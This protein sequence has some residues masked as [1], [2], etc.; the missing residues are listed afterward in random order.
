MRKDHREGAPVATHHEPIPSGDSSSDA[1]VSGAPAQPT[2]GSAPRRPLPA[3]VTAPVADQRGP[4]SGLEAHPTPAGPLD[5][6]TV[7]PDYPPLADTLPPAPSSPTMQTQPVQT[8]GIPVAPVASAPV[9]PVTSAPVPP[10]AGQVPPVAPA[11]A[12]SVPVPPVASGPV[13]PPIASAPVPPVASAP[14]PPVASAPV[15]SSPVASGPVGSAPV[16]SAGRPFSGSSPRSFP[17]SAP[18]AP[19]AQAGQP[20]FSVPGLEHVIVPGAAQPVQPAEP[21]QQQIWQRWEEAPAPA[22]PTPAAFTPPAAGV[23][24]PAGV[25][26]PVAVPTPVGAPVPTA[27]PFTDVIAPQV[28]ESPAPTKAEQRAAAKQAKADAAAAAKQAKTD[29]ATAAKQ[30]KADKAT[31]AKRSKA[32]AA[33]TAKQTKAAEADAAKQAKADAAA[34]AAQTK[35]D[36]A[37][38]AAQAE[39]DAAAAAAA[40]AAAEQARALPVPEPVL[41]VAY[42]TADPLAAEI[43]TP[44]P[45]PAPADAPEHVATPTPAPAA[46]PTGTASDAPF[47]TR[48]SQRLLEEQAGRRRPRSGPAPSSP[49]VASAPRP[50]SPF[51][52]GRRQ[53]PVAAP[54]PRRTGNTAPT[55]IV[56]TL[57]APAPAAA[58]VA[59]AENPVTTSTPAVR[60]AIGAAPGAVI[61]ALFG[62]GTLGVALWWFLNPGTVHIVAVVLGVLAVA[63]TLSTLRNPAALSWHRAMSLLGFVFGLIG[64]VVLLYAIASA[65]ASVAGITLPDVTG[66][67][68]APSLNW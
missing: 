63:L 55:P 19:E 28:A 68:I 8:G 43:I 39:A 48:R 9:P 7:I 11:A 50:T 52:I 42:A 25:P 27:V 38:A 30:A 37:A 22:L 35:A 47:P 2:P 65:F 54:G 18:L 51:R 31:A 10:V 4:V 56:A 1:Q 61:G 16:T 29:K 36:A 45:A 23:P 15:A 41:P 12:A 21:A 59:V 14:V 49:A 60:T 26:T 44:T 67:G 58:A 13:V 6:N 5:P 3:W 66:T 20:R 64:T 57:P 17:G 33:A 46:A 32:D 53:E 62:L 40:A 24:A 34:A